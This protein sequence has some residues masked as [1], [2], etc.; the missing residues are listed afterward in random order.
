M[1]AF[2]SAAD[3]RPFGFTPAVV[4]P[5]RRAS[6]SF[7]LQLQADGQTFYIHLEPN[8][9]LLHPDL[10]STQHHLSSLRLYK[11]RVLIPAHSDDIMQ[12]GFHSDYLVPYQDEHPDDLGWARFTFRNLS[13]SQQAD[14]LALVLQDVK[15][16][17]P[18]F[19]GIFTVGKELY[20]VKLA[21]TY[22]RIR[23]PIDKPLDPSHGPQTLLIYKESDR[24]PS[25]PWTAQDGQSFANRSL[26]ISQAHV[27]SCGHDHS[28][29]NSMKAH[30]FYL[31]KLKKHQEEER[32][33]YKLNPLQK[34]APPGC[35][36]SKKVLYMV[37]LSLRTVV[38]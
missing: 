34:R 7:R 9:H 26:A 20:N 29:F 6:D 30:D 12:K 37:C 5:F 1:A 8:E 14:P 38:A 35:P 22:D 13:P 19:E 16:P 17:L 28:P 24:K 32:R 3:N 10:T 23:R 15:Q 18:P 11:G 36:V 27:A 4:P 33:R 25:T 31:D 21:E 2:T